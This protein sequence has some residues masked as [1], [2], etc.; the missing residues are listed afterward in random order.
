VLT[1]LRYAGGTKSY[2]LEF[3]L[4][5][6]DR[7]IVNINQLILDRVLDRNGT[8]LPLDLRS[9]T[10]S[11]RELDR[12]G[13]GALFEG[14]VVADKTWGHAAYG[15]MICCGYGLPIMDP[16]PTSTFVSGFE[17]AEVLAEETCYGGQEWVTNYF[18]TWWTGNTAIAT[19]QWG[20]WNGV[21]T[22]STL[23]YAR[24]RLPYGDGSGGHLSCPTALRTSSQTVPVNPTV[25]IVS[26]RGYLFI[27]NDA[28]VSEQNY[29]FAQG[30]PSGG[31]Y[32]W[33]SSAGGISFASPNSYS[34]KVTVTSYTGGIH[35]TPIIVNYAQGGRSAAPDTTYITRRLFKFLGSPLKVASPI[36][37]GSYGYA[38][39]VYYNVYTQPSSQLLEPGF[40]GI[41]TV[42]TI[43]QGSH[44]VEVIPVIQNG[45]TDANSRVSDYLAFFD[46][47]PLPANALSTVS[48]DIAVGGFFVRKNTL[49][50]RSTDVEIVSNG[51]AN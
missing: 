25:D 18:D 42:E 11:I 34:T 50:F 8:A 26:T 38:F 21:Y 27:G 14:K 35:D 33:S 49:N 48:Q 36:P 40:S 16:D 20:Q 12:S 7:R 37:S 5:P 1:T 13:Y 4:A 17:Y 41:S 43:T 39:N 15:C 22:G 46:D 28:T 6:S 29:M 2:E 19:A 32:S 30:T 31:T 47:E 3:P 24:G 9:G 23:G 51:P 10:Y 44:N 45:A